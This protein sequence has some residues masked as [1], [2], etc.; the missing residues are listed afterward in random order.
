MLYL[1]NENKV[2]L[3]FYPFLGNYCSQYG[4]NQLTNEEKQKM[5][6]LDYVD[7]KSRKYGKKESCIHPDDGFRIFFFSFCFKANIVLYDFFFH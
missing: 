4:S 7:W 6:S 3:L 5:V 2:L 1:L